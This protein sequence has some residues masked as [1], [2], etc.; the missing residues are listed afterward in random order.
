M[1]QLLS[2]PANRVWTIVCIALALVYAGALTSQMVNQIQHAPAQA[3]HHD[4]A[5]FGSAFELPANSRAQDAHHDDEVGGD[6]APDHMTGGH[7]HHGDTGPSVMANAVPEFASVVPFERLRASI[8]DR[9]IAGIHM[10]GP[11][12]PPR[13]R[14]LTA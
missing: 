4:H 8:T 14:Q 12:R 1:S 10:P 7:H 2:S 3:A 9:Q 13:Q 5:F 11:E 6:E